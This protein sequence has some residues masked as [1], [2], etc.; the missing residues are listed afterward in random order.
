MD[1]RRLPIIGDDIYQAGQVVDIFSQPCAPEPTIMVKAFFANVPMLIWSLYKPDPF[2]YLT[3]RFGR[4]HKRRRKGRL[5]VG[6]ID[7]APPGSGK[8]ARWVSFTG[9][10]I[11]ERVG[12][13]F[14][15]AD[16]TTDFAINWTSMAYRFSGCQDPLSGYAQSIDNDGFEFLSTGARFGF[17]GGTPSFTTGYTAFSASVAK[18]NPGP[19]GVS[20]FAEFGLRPAA[21]RGTVQK[22]E[23]EQQVGAVFTNVD[24]D[25]TT[26]NR[27]DYM[28]ASGTNLIYNS[29]EP[30]ATYRLFMTCTPGWIKVTRWG[31][32]ISGFDEPGVG[33]DP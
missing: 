32:T 25:L 3:T 1:I 33:P 11:A 9:T 31:L 26:P 10:K 19:R 2:D 12:W 20:G 5:H 21:S 23:I 4:G 30:A 27:E 6:N 29:F 18:T 17:S 15:V 14:L 22:V 13:Y 8:G 28:A 24:A 7:T 16:A